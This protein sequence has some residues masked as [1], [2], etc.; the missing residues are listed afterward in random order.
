MSEFGEFVAFPKITRHDHPVMITEKIDGTNGCIAFDENGIIHVQ[1]RNKIITPGKQTDNAGLARW[2][3]D[4]S[5]ELFDLL[6]PGYHYGEWWGQ[7]IQRGYGRGCKCFSL[8]NAGRWADVDMVIGDVPVT[9][10]PVLAEG[11]AWSDDLQMDVDDMLEDYG[12]FAAPG[13]SKPEGY[14]IWFRN[15][16]YLKRILDK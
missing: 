15:G 8:F 14:M 6:G 2:A 3:Y 12:S 1:S 7:G 13:W 11:R 5:D 9:H 4:H 10:V 16:M